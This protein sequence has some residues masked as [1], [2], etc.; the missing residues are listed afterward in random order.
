VL[1]RIANSP[2]VAALHDGRRGRLPGPVLLLGVAAAYAA[3]AQL[4]F[5]LNGPVNMGAGFWPAAGLSLGVLVLVAPSRWGWVLAG[6]GLAELGGDLAQG[7]PL[8]AALWWTAG[9]CIG[10]VVGARMLRRW[11]NPSGSIAPVSQLWWFFAAAIVVA[12][13]AGASI[14][15]V[16]TVVAHGDAGLWQVWPRSVVG[17]A[18]GVLAVTPLLLCWDGRQIA[19]RRR[20]TVALAVAL[21]TVTFVTFRAW[22]EVWDAA[23]PY[24]V[25]PLLSWAALR[26]GCR[27]AAIAVFT[28]TQ[29]ANWS[30]ATATGPFAATGAADGQAITLLQVFLVISAMLTFIL[31]ALVEDLVDRAEV[32]SRLELQAATDAL[33]GLPNRAVLTS[34]LHL[35]LAYLSGAGDVGVF[36]CD[37]D[38]FKVVND[39]LGHL[40]GDEVLVEVARRMRRCVRPSDLVARL[41]GDEFVVVMD[42]QVSKLEELAQRLIDAVAEPM[43]LT[44]GIKLTPSISVGIANGGPGTDPVALLRDAD[45][46]LYRAKELGRG[47]FQR[48]DDHLRLRVV[49]RLL[50][51][52]ELEGALA[53]DDLYCVYQPEIVIASGRLFSLEALARWEHPVQGQIPPSRFVPVIED[54]G[55]SDR[56]FEHVLDEALGAQAQWAKR[57]GFHPALAI[58]LSASQLG[59][60]DLPGVVAKALTRGCAPADSLWIEVTESAIAVESASHTLLELHLLGVRLVIDDFGTGWSSM[61]RLAAFP[62]DLLKIDRTFVAALG[63]PFQHAEQVVRSTIAM[64]HGLGVPTTAEGVETPEQLERLAALDCDIAQGFLFAQPQVARHAI[65]DVTDEGLWVGPGISCVGSR[66][67]RTSV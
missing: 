62:W 66:G 30:A 63:G 4:A 48:F 25:I 19:R 22:G 9:H 27:G 67:R 2:T 52:T 49:D 38:H 31:A 51:Q 57:L 6:V 36:A 58:N 24:L 12:P 18:L 56:L 55:N 15:S 59:N 35:G 34:S 1:L 14:G 17:H 29:I 16:G 50:I 40:A 61:T 3:L 7:Y 39:G 8:D 13:L 10:P 41:G 5:W 65:D 21:I 42:G 46:A 23:L 37:L 32:E 64:A 45:T 33:T 26:Y 44:S 54:M 20:E 47:R 60:R 43:T 11:D 28:V 53:A